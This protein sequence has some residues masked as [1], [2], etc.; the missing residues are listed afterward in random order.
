MQVAPELL[1]KMAVQ[2][3]LVE[4][5]KL[6]PPR[7]D[8]AHCCPPVM[9]PLLLTSAHPVV[10]VKLFPEGLGI[11]AVADACVYS[12]KRPDTMIGSNT[13]EDKDREWKA[14]KERRRALLPAS[15]VK[16]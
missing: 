15:V 10:P 13:A 16:F 7:E 4:H 3:A 1:P 14:E 6:V 12:G 5:V 8:C 9:A 11:A 2:S